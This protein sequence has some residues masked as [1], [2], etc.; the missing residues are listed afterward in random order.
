MSWPHRGG[1]QEASFFAHAA[2]PIPGHRGRSPLAS[3]EWQSAS[4]HA[5][6]VQT[7]GPATLAVDQLFEVAQGARIDLVKLE[8]REFQLGMSE[9][10]P[11]R[12]ASL[13]FD[14]PE[15]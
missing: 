11:I 5:L 3:G 10:Q 13:R 7:A 1:H 4:R 9:Y 2:C 15:F 14:N 6:V 8:M 12:A